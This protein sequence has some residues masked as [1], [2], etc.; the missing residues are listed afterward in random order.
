MFYDP[1]T[2]E[3]AVMRS[4]GILRTFFKPTEGAGYWR[5]ELAKI[6]KPS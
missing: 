1:A 4:D 6:N 2:D 5:G 3:L